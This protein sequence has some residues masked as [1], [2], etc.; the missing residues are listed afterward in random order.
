MTGRGFFIAI[1]G[2]DGAGKGGVVAA[3]DAALAAAG[4]DIL[5]TREPGGTPEGEALR[6]LL[7]AKNGPDWDPRAELLLMTAA[8]VQHVEQVIR[9]ALAAGRVV[10][11]DRYLGS[12]LAYQG[13]G[14][15]LATTDILALH[16]MFLGDLRPHLT[17]VIDVDPAVGLDRSRSRLAGTARDEGRFEAI[18]GGFHARVRNA[19]LAQAASDP[20][21]H[22]VLDGHMS[23]ANLHA[24]A[25]AT[26][27]EALANLDKTSQKG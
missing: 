2:G 7:V 15:G 18:A 4:H 3:L 22:R 11:C 12:T 8:R 16:H 9:P 20:A 17:L 5:T 10:L 14:R 19:F 25:A 21:R 6:T 1:E 27:L 24:A 23:A 26:V 13:A